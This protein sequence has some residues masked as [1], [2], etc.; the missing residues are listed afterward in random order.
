MKINSKLLFVSTPI[1]ALST[2]LGGGVELT[3]DNAAKAIQK[4]GH[5]VKVIAPINSQLEGVSVQEISGDLQIPTQNQNRIDPVLIPSD[6]VLAN[7]WDYVRQV[8]E[9][10]DL[11]VN[12]SYD[13]LPLYLTPFLKRP[14][15]HLISMSSLTNAMDKAIEKVLDQ[16]PDS[17]AVHGKTQAASFSFH[18]KLICI[19]NG[20][21][22][23]QYHFCENPEDYIAWVGRIAPE[24]GLEDAFAVSE[25]TKI[26]L[27]IFGLKQDL[28]YWDKVCAS[29]P[30]A[31][32]EY[33][34]FFRTDKLQDELGRCRAVLITPHWI[35]AF[36]NVA[37]EALACGVPVIAYKRGGPSEIV[38][39]GK[40]GWLVEPNNIKEL[41]ASVSRLDQ[42]NR[43]VCRQQAE[44]L[45]SL[46]SFGKRLESWFEK[47]VYR[48]VTN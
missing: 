41:V 13:W 9:D 32:V 29:Y 14:V 46:E 44:L 12:F 25:I 27:K 2:G 20:L 26:P 36:G 43:S 10:Y 30:N 19:F 6:S 34:G 8:Q 40:T 39:D 28:I 38:E 18:D 31:P 3:L 4:R 23:S 7:M 33:R 22:M 48:R 24:K 35:E 45:Y 15:A 47:I 21:D 16:F 42:I 37:I 5:T 1:G 11:I 17:V